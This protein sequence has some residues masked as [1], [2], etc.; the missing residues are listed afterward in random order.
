MKVQIKM[1]LE[2]ETSET[3]YF[4]GINKEGKETF[5]SNWR[6]KA[7]LPWGT[8]YTETCFGAQYNTKQAAIK[9]LKKLIKEREQ[10]ELGV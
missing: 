1:N 6:A 4:N 3:L 10:H 7:V 2:I 9:A 5:V 8:I